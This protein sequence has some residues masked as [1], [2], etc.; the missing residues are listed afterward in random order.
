M[1]CKVLAGALMVMMKAANV[2]EHAIADPVVLCFWSEERYYKI[3][4]IILIYIYDI[5]WYYIYNYIYIYDIMYLCIYIYIVVRD[6][7]GILRWLWVALRCPPVSWTG[8]ASS[9][10]ICSRHEA[11]W[12]TMQV[13]SSC[14]PRMEMVWSRQTANVHSC[15]WRPCHDS[16]HFIHNSQSDE[17]LQSKYKKRKRIYSYNLVYMIKFNFES[18]ILINPFLPAAAPAAAT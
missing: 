1:Q 18:D 9:L 13:G 11:L 10:S 16:Q 8:Q 5:S 17:P 2:C 3:L 7:T 4:L 6:D 15:S 14:R 12:F